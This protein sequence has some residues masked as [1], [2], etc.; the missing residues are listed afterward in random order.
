[1]LERQYYFINNTESME[2]AHKAM[3][4]QQPNRTGYILETLYFITF[5][6]NITYSLHCLNTYIYA[7]YFH[8]LIWTCF[9]IF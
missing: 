7:K 1:M 4:T 5:V 6:L 3:Y 8:G 9:W 2:I